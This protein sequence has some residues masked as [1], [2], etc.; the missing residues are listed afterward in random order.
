MKLRLKY[1]PEVRA[2]KPKYAMPDGSYP[3]NTCADVHSAAVLAHHSKT[4]G[5]AQVKAYVLKAKAGLGCPDSVLPDT[6]DESNASGKV[7]Q[8]R[9]TS[10]GYSPVPASPWHPDGDADDDSSP[11]TDS[12]HDFWTEAGVPIASAW[13]AQGM[14]IPS[15]PQKQYS[16]KPN[17]ETR[18]DPQAPVCPV[19]GSLSVDAP[20]EGDPDVTCSNCGAVLE[21][22]DEDDSVP[23]GI[24][25]D[26][27]D[28]VNQSSSGGVSGMNSKRMPRDNL[29]RAIPHSFEVRSDAQSLTPEFQ[30]I[31]SRFNDWYPVSELG[32]G[33][34]MEQVL[35]GAFTDTI[36]RDKSSMRVLFN[37]G[38]DP[39]IGDKP[40]G[41][42][43]TL[44]EQDDGPYFDGP[45]LDTGYNRD[46]IIP[47]LQGRL[48]DGTK[49]GS[50]LG[51]SFRFSVQEDRWNMHPKSTKMN[52]NGIPQRS[53]VRAKVF[54]FGPVTFP[55]NAGATA[56]ARS[57][58][59][60]WYAHLIEDTWFQRQFAERVGTKVAE[61]IL[62]SLTP[63]VRQEIV[64]QSKRS[65]QDRLKRRAKALLA[66]SA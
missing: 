13:L 3:I 27:A 28:G 38:Q 12:D 61:R 19:C 22:D 35:P 47:M 6:W 24:P 66:L 48:M 33:D 41:P 34:F 1:D 62:N 15:I 14:V 29:I 37:H 46:E 59:D 49:V 43:R 31:F 36:K 17:G 50:Q 42:I 5:F 16:H 7:G 11:E 45:F 26:G 18:L 8:I 25:S 58:T 40:L 52:P 23:G 10:N 53:I 65:H 20:D 39:S 55:A 63:E 32:M 64:H 60:D 30:G 9:A 51:S 54:E 4:Y 57:L 21:T 56:S 44:K 2:D